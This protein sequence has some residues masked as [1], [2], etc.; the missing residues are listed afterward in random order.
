MQSPGSDH[1]NFELDTE[2]DAEP[3][4]HQSDSDSAPPATLKLAIEAQIKAGL[5]HVNS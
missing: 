4:K 5:E 2:S 3:V 1:K